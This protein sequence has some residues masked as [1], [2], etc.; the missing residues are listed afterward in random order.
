MCSEWS[1]LDGSSSGSGD[2]DDELN[3]TREGYLQNNI[4]LTLKSVTAKMRVNE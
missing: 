3:F 1:E 2:A 4:T